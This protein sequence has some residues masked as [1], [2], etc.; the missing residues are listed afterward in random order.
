MALVPV[1]VLAA[2]EQDTSTNAMHEQVRPTLRRHALNRWVKN[3]R[4]NA[5]MFALRGPGPWTMARLTPSAAVRRYERTGPVDHRGLARVRHA[6]R[7]LLAHVR[8]RT[9]S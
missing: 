7:S 8:R 6:A 9:V 5:P 3:Y 2:I 4:T 1:V